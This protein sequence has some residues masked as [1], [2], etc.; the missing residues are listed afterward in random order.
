M[1]RKKSFSTIVNDMARASARAERERQQQ[2]KAHAREVERVKRE[3]ARLDAQSQ[4]D[5]KQ[6]YIEERAAQVDEANLE[7][8]YRLE[9]LTSVLETTLNKDDTVSFASL[10]SSGEF[11]SFQLPPELK[12]V[13]EEPQLESFKSRVSKPSSLGRLIPGAAKK[14]EDAIKRAEADYQEAYSAYRMQ[15]HQREQKIAKL[16]G[17]Y[18]QQKEL[19]EQELRAHNREIEEFENA[20]KRG[21]PSAVIA[22]CSMVLERSEYPGGFPQE[23]RAAY[24]PES[25]ELVV[26]YELPGTSVVPAV[27]EDKAT[28][29]L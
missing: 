20:Y 28:N 16:R 18:D 21:D 3:R 23:F 2:E 19:F 8:K 13:P 4:K 27:A 7:L 10:R 9:Q 6:R 29:F 14:H 5:Q 1:A 15:V 26:E 12:Q 24:I 17:E 22:Y 25:K 11:R